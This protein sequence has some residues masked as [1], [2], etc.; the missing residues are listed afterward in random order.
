MLI[1]LRE[2]FDEGCDCVS[3][4]KICSIYFVFLFLHFFRVVVEVKTIIKIFDRN[5]VHNMYH[6]FETVKKFV[7][8]LKKLKRYI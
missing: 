3:S 5:R 1:V 7:D 2:R 8:K 6:D 4:I